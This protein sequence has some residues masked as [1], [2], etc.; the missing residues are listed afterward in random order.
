MTSFVRTLVAAIAVVTLSDVAA[1]QTAAPK[2][3]Y[4][5][6][7]LL[8][9]SAPGRA[10]AEAQFQRDV[11][12]FQA[13]I[14]RMGDS[15]NTMMQEYERAEV[16]LS[17]AAK[18]SRQKT[19]RARETEYQTRAQTLRTQ[20][21]QREGELARPIMDQINKILDVIRA[22]EGYMFIFDVGSTAAVIVA[23]DKNLD[24]TDRVIARLQ[25]TTA[26][27]PARPTGAPVTAPSGVSRPR[28]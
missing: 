9:Q 19:L 3:A 22:E 7:Q 5:N 21:E 18:E 24:I 4:V 27:A 14:K 25:T 6:S 8:M 26:A 2:F 12:G 15:L 13:Q 10:A 1:A 23:A 11:T 17:P 28:P 16:S 20:M